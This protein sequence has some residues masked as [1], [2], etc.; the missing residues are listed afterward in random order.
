MYVCVYVVMYVCVVGVMKIE[1]IAPRSGIEPSSLTLQASV[2][3]ITPALLP[4]VTT[5]STATLE[6]SA[7]YYV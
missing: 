1:N 6:V 4:A 3:T 2:R 7:D 5:L